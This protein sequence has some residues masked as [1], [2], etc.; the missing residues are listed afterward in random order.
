MAA[1]VYALCAA[2]SLLCAGL[3]LRAYARSQ[4]RLLLWSGISFVG[5]SVGNVLM[6][7]DFVILPQR[8]LSLL[9]AVTT[10]VS[11]GVLVYGLLSEDA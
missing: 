7:T 2:A 10:C 11:I 5:L 6:F 3:L 1:S 9:R 8:D 4:V